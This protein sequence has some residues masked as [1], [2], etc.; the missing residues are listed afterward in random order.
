[1]AVAPEQAGAV[2]T[3]FAAA[4]LSVWQVG[5]VVKGEGVQVVP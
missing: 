2:E 4:E 5:D 3:R 1:M